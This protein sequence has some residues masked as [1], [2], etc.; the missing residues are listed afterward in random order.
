MI[1]TNPDSERHDTANY[2]GLTCPV[3]FTMHGIPIPDDAELYAGVDVSCGCGK[4]IVLI[5]GELNLVSAI[6]E[7]DHVWNHHLIC[8]V[9]DISRMNLDKLRGMIES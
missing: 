4:N 6:L 1:I 2:I 7:C 8:D 3:C 9:C 5:T